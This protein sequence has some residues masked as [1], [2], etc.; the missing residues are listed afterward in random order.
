MLSKLPEVN[1]SVLKYLMEFLSTVTEHSF[2]NKMTASNLA[3]VFGPNLVWPK[4]ESILLSNIG[5][6]NSFTEYALVMH[7]NIFVVM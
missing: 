4:D 1:Y 5:A 3:I 7:K 6:V 2:L